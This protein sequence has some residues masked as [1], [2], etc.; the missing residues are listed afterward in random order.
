MC[1]RYRGDPDKLQTWRE[2][3]GYAI[4]DPDGL[5]AIDA[6]DQ[7]PGRPA[8]VVRAVEGVTA[9]DALIW[10][11]PTKKERKR[12]PKEGQ[13][14][15]IVEWW[16]N[17]RNLDSNMWRPWLEKPGHRCLVPFTSFAEPAIGCGREN[18]WFTT[19]RPVACFAGVWKPSFE[20]EVFAFLTT[21]P[22]PLV[23]PLHPKAMPVVLAAED[24]KA[25]LT[26][27]WGD[28]RKLA[29]PYPSQLM[30]VKSP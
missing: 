8:A 18:H 24:E 14:P 19:E 25:W 7:W 10:G 9:L 26:A 30:S 4:R 6:D 20:G 1:N 27:P 29:A 21:D 12:P 5:A 17:A 16:T 11:F 13:K 28:A 22:N 2:Y 23:A 15:Y 3:A